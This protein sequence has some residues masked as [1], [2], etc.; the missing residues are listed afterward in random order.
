MTSAADQ[1]RRAGASA[2][3]TAT[4]A[5]FD[6]L[7]ARHPEQFR[8]PV[9]SRLRWGAII[10]VMVATVVFSGWRLDME[11]WR[12]MSGFGRL[13]HVLSLMLPPTSDTWEKFFVYLQALGETVG[14]SLLGTVIA[15]AI[16]VPFCL[17]ASRNV[18]PIWPVQFLTRRFSDSLRGVDQLIW[19]L[20]W[21]GVVGLGPMAGVLA[22]ATADI[23]TFIKIFSEAIET[24][25]RKPVEGVTS[26]GGSPWQGVRFGIFPQV[27]P[28]IAGQ[29]LYQF[30]SN[31]RHSTII[32]V[33]GGGG[34]GLHLSEQ[35][36]TLEWQHVSLL[37]IMILITVAIIDFVSTR[38]RRAIMGQSKAMVR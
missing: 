1:P 21:V 5:E 20:I 14:M 10:A 4:L 27:I 9:A 31:T 24:A 32:G 6:A 15:A 23:G 30:E 12:I 7:K 2:L 26:T 8:T 19:A 35:I 16:A 11:F 18:M 36:R 37:I 34:I 29:I 28:V 17:L 38:L 33:V 25:D 13:G 3:R 22:I